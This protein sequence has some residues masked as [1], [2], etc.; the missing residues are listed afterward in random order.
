MS[1]ADTNNTL[2]IRLGSYLTTYNSEVMRTSIFLHR[3]PS[4]FKAHLGS[5][6]DAS[7]WASN[8]FQPGAYIKQSP[9]F[10]VIVSPG[11]YSF[12]L[13]TFAASVLTSL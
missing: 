1:S 6:P 8:N 4:F 12:C 2:F 11:N 5:H 9:Y 3:S 13:V 7:H 10:R